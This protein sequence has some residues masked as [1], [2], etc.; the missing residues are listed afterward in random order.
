MLLLIKLFKPT[1]IKELGDLRKFPVQA[2]FQAT[3]KKVFALKIYVDVLKEKI[4][5]R[6]VCV[7]R[8][9]GGGGGGGSVLLLLCIYDKTFLLEIV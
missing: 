4:A 6:M 3:N 8:G 7:C 9:G 2:P 1:T 5:G